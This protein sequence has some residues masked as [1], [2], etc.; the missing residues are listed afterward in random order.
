MIAGLPIYTES[1]W[2]GKPQGFF[3]QNIMRTVVMR[4]DLIFL[5]KSIRSMT[6]WNYKVINK[7]NFLK[8]LHLLVMVL[9]LIVFSFCPS[10]AKDYTL[11]WEANEEPNVEGYKLYYSIDWPGPPYEGLHPLYPHSDSPIDV[12]N[13]TEYTLHDLEDDVV[14]YF[15]ITAYDSEGNESGYSN[16]VSTADVDIQDGFRSL[17][18]GDRGSD[19]TGCFIQS[20]K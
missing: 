17:S 15:V 20:T 1:L 7:Q 5:L 8:L 4:Q 19:A 13:V 6:L 3:F 12:G 16:Q 2:V 11:E 14:Y 9:L 18:S 10:L